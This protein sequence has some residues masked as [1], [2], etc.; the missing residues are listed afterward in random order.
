MKEIELKNSIM[1]DLRSIEYKGKEYFNNRVYDGYREYLKVKIGF[2][3]FGICAD[4]DAIKE[5]VEKEREGFFG[6]KYK[7]KDE[8]FRGYKLNYICFGCEFDDD[9]W[10]SL[11]AEEKLSSLK[12]FH[13]MEDV[14]KHQI[15]G[16]NKDNKF[17]F[18]KWDYYDLPYKEEI[19]QIITDFW[20]LEK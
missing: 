3:V 20:N 13:K 12:D 18:P 5:V 15:V 4:F 14:N 7:Y 16:Y 17:V 10:K 6:S 2:Y 9:Y 19:K 11:S 1:E 8:E